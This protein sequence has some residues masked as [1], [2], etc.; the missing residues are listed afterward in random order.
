MGPATPMR[1][2]MRQV[3]SAKPRISVLITQENHVT[4]TATV[5]NGLRTF[6]IR[7]RNEKNLPKESLIFCGS[8]SNSSIIK[9][10][11]FHYLG[12]LR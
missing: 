12:P 7:K 11:F 2:R 6:F 8:L 4:H 3:H 1:P 10:R 9:Q 5:L